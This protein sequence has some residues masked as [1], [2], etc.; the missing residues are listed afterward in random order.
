MFCNTSTSDQTAKEVIEHRH[1]ANGTD[2]GAWK[3][4][5]HRR[6]VMWKRYDNSQS[7]HSLVR[8]NENA[9]LF[10]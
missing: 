2:G 9:H 8:A 7:E 4:E 1:G 10:V 3:E 6:N 5:E